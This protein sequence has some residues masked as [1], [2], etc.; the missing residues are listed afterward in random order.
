MIPLLVLFFPGQ[1]AKAQTPTTRV[2]WDFKV[3]TVANVAT[4][5]HT[6]RVDST[7]I[8]TAPTCVQVGPDVTCSV[9]IGTLSS[10][11]HTVSVKATKNNVSSEMTVNGLNGVN[12]PKSPEGIRININVTVTI[13]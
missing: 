5:A 2:E 7:N 3:D 1:V 8:T 13:P 10:G 9:P 11:T 12:G 4:Y 6:V